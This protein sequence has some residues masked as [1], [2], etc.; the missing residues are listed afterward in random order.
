MTHLDRFVIGI[1]NVAHGFLSKLHAESVAERNY[2]CW[3]ALSIT[4]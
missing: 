3:Q 1:Y 2:F 4:R